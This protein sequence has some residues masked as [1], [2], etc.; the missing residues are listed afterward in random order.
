MGLFDKLFK[1]KNKK[2][3]KIAPSELNK[4][5]NFFSKEELMDI[6]TIEEIKRDMNNK[7]KK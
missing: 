4:D 5:T 7:F 1:G 2:E 6:R 3:K